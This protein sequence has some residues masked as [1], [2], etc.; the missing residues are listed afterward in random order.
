MNPNIDIHEIRELLRE[1]RARLSERLEDDRARTIEQGN[2]VE[3]GD[4][5]D[6][7][8]H[9][10]NISMLGRF[11]EVEHRQLMAIDAAMERIE[12]GTYGECMTCGEEIDPARLR[13][14]PEA[15]RCIACMEEAAKV[16]EKPGA[17]A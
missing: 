10:D 14:L 9:D 8:T 3:P 5:A 11:S 4:T 13:A 1:R 16:R 12:N 17:T 7:A 2:L 6:M 15:T